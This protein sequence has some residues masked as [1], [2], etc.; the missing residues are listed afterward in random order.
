[1][2]ASELKSSIFRTSKGTAIHYLQAGNSN[3]PLLICLHGLGGSTETFVPLLPSLPTSYNVILVDFQGF[4]KS[5]VSAEGPFS[6]GGHVSDIHHLI[7]SLQAAPGS[8]SGAQKVGRHCHA[9][10]VGWGLILSLGRHHRPFPRR[11]RRPALCRR[12]RPRRRRSR[13]TCRWPISRP[14]PDRPPTND[15]PGEEH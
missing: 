14:H 4:G 6:V 13:A 3:G 10:S 8:E 7:T 12:A 2:T 5:P 9:F 1:M 15:R 11:H